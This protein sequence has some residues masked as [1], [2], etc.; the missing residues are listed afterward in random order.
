MVGFDPDLPKTLVHTGFAPRRTTVRP[1][2]EV[3]HRLREVP[4]RLLLH[5]CDPSPA[6]R[7]PHAPRSIARTARC[8]RARG[9][10][11]AS[12]LLL[13]GQVPRIPRVPAM[14]GQHRRLFGGKNNR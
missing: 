11:A 5:G 4:Q 14:L 13:D 10:P 1:G 2:E 12:A 9:A 3:A 6:N 8:S 7:T